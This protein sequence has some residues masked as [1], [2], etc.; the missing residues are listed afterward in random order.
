VENS[1]PSL[2]AQEWI[3]SVHDDGADTSAEAKGTSA[4]AV[5]S[6]AVT[7]RRSST[8]AA[9]TNYSG[10]RSGYLERKGEI[11]SHTKEGKR[12]E[13]IPREFLFEVENRKYDEDRDRDYLLNDL[14]L[15]S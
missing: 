1:E 6:S 10:Y 2:L 8:R 5:V 15:K 12:H 14:E 3:A 11:C 7:P 4:L 13:I 9:R